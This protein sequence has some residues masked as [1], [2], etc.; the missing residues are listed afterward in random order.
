MKHKEN[1]LIQLRNR[2]LMIAYKQFLKEEFERGDKVNRQKIVKRI[3]SEYKPH[4]HVSY[5]HA[6]KVLTTI[7]NHGTQ[8][9]KKTL[10]QQM[11]QE[12]LT[13][14]EQEMATHP[15]LNMGHALSRVLITKRASRFYLSENYCYKYLYYC[16][17][18]KHHNHHN[19]NF[20]AA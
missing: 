7:R 1:T 16:H 9:F 15:R 3:L 18:E 14:V 13:L 6:Y 10:R 19:R 5:E 17:N 4:F 8:T 20:Y 11:W 12:L 2:E